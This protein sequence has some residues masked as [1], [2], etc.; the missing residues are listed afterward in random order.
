MQTPSSP[1]TRGEWRPGLPATSTGPSTHPAT[2]APRATLSAKPASS[3]STAPDARR[4][5]RRP[6][7]RRDASRPRVETASGAGVGGR[8]TRSAPARAGGWLAPICRRRPDRGWAPLRPCADARGG[9]SPRGS[10]ADQGTRDGDLW[11]DTDVQGTT[12]SARPR[13]GLRRGT[14]HATGQRGR[15]WSD[16]YPR[17]G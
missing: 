3:R 12:R 8:A 6:P 15:G 10:L 5:A 2:S 4:Q 14:P 16:V 7:S 13:A 17:G 1:L 9:W 11:A